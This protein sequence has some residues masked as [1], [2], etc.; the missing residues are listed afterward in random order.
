MSCKSVKKSDISK[1]VFETYPAIG[2]GNAKRIVDLVF[3]IIAQEMKQG[4]RVT[5]TRFGRFEVYEKSGRGL[6]NVQ[7]GKEIEIPTKYYPKFSPSQ[8]L[9]DFVAEE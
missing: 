6:V 5:I 9:V 1:R 4:N 7:T 2:K 3:D 8:Q